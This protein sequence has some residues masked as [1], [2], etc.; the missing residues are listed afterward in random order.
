MKKYTITQ[1][2]VV[3]KILKKLDLAIFWVKYL[4]KWTSVFYEIEFVFFLIS[5][6]SGLEKLNAVMIDFF[7]YYSC[8][9]MRDRLLKK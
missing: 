3:K 4:E 8:M 9:R 2:N 1:W 6:R 5:C 7:N